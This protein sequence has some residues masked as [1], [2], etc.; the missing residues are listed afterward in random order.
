MVDVGAAIPGLRAHMDLTDGSSID[1][2]HHVGGSW[3]SSEDPRIHFGLPRDAEIDRLQ[4]WAP[5]GMVLYD[6]SPDK[7]QVLAIGED[8][9]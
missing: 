8:D 3:L 5:D 2:L 4:V 6:G 9:R 7:N 1:R